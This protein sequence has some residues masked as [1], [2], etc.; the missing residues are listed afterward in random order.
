MMRNRSTLEIRGLNRRQFCKAGLVA[1]AGLTLPTPLLA[2]SAESLPP[3][4]QLSF[5]HTH[6]GETLNSATYWAN[7]TVQPSALVDIYQILRDHRSHEISAIDLE[8]L[9][10]LVLLNRTL[11]NREPLHVISGFRSVKTNQYLRSKS[12]GGGVAKYSLHMDGRAIDI[13]VPGFST[14]QLH[15]TAVSLKKGGVGLY[16][17]L[18]FVHIDTGPIKYWQ[19]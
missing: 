14:E 4:R 7:G 13:R 15:Q 18:K 8:L 5:Y 2:D 6:T 12:Q 19:G 16:P 17:G 10:Q 11:D 1:L 9:D 3:E